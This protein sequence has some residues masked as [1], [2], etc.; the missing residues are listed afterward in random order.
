[1]LTLMAL[2]VPSSLRHILH[3]CVTIL[4][5][6]MFVPFC[7]C[8]FLL[9]LITHSCLS[10]TCPSSHTLV[11]IACCLLAGISQALQA[12]LMS[13]PSE[14][15]ASF[16][17][18]LLK[19]ATVER[20]RTARAYFDERLEQC[21]ISWYQYAEE[22]QDFVLADMLLDFRDEDDTFSISFGTDLIA[23][24]QKFYGGRRRFKV[25]FAIISAW[26]VATPSE[27][28]PPI[29][30]LVC[31]AWAA[32]MFGAMKPAL[33]VTSLLC[34]CGL[35]R[36]GEALNLRWKDVVLPS[37]HRSGA[38][39]VLLLRIT[40]R[41][42]PESQKVYLTNT[43]LI[44]ILERYHHVFSPAD[45]ELRFVPMS[46]GTFARWFQRGLLTLGLGAKVYRSH[47]LRRGG[48]TALALGGWRLCDITLAGRWQQEKT[49][50]LYVMKGEVLLLRTRRDLSN[51]QWTRIEN[52]AAMLPAVS[53]DAMSVKA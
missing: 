3:K 34:F 29:P 35:L 21:N 38:F 32:I 48:A 17:L 5:F 4:P 44:A 40:K 43:F 27:S 11:S 7:I 15:L 12:L 2:F 16:L 31:Y 1:V 37:M 8:G 36:I 14:R 22:Q 42:S 19:P 13:G 33:A 18:T 28:A 23:S 46:Y 25:A 24:L 20:Y 9:R 10:I 51:S 52:L 6:C 50:K 39:V 53:V 26:Q 41:G 47:S 45:L 30:D 49:A